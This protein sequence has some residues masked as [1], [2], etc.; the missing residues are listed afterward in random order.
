MTKTGPTGPADTGVKTSTGA[1][2]PVKPTTTGPT[3]PT[4]DIGSSTSFALAMYAFQQNTQ[5][6]NALMQQRQLLLKH[7]YDQPLT[8]EERS[9]LDPTL[10][11]AVESNDKNQMDLSLRLI[12]D[13]LQ[14]RTNT[15][16]Q[17]LKYL[18]DIY[19]TDVT[20]AENKRKDAITAVY[21][22][23]RVY[24]AN[25]GA[26]IKALYGQDYVDQLASL[27]I[28]VEA[29]SKIPVKGTTGTTSQFTKTQIAKGAATA[30]MS[31]TNFENLDEDTQNFF[32]NE[33]AMIDDQKA[34]IDAAV[35]DST[36]D[37]D[38]MENLINDSD[39][40]DVVKDYLIKYLKSKRPVAKPPTTSGRVWYE[41]WTWF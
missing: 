23:A 15:L 1:T 8:D 28:D 29:L 26:A 12:S 14:G 22:F 9:K 3:L 13:E 10:L 34:V 27:G 25:T 36:A 18:V 32:I 21:D 5:K 19:Q 33:K 4:G 30:D 38:A 35:T 16:D 17:S 40:P 24:G 37:W 41:P 6:N 11:P 7:L 2:G 31:I 20:A 39:Y